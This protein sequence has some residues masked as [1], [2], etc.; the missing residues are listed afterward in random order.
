MFYSTGPDVSFNPQNLVL[1]SVAYHV[2]IFI[3]QVPGLISKNYF[4]FKFTHTFYKR[5]RCINEAIIFLCC[6]KI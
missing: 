2:K 6:K 3:V 5:D 1:I 4:G